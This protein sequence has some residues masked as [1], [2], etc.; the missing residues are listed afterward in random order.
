MNET[1][2]RLDGSFKQS[3]HWQVMKVAFGQIM[4]MIVKH[5][6]S[7]TN[8]KSL[9]TLEIEKRGIRKTIK[10]FLVIKEN[11]IVVH[12]WN[13]FPTEYVQSNHTYI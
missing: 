1:L 3:N 8:Y 4:I 7:K 10:K 2:Y 9:P 5:Y 6:I 12:Q 13:N 11:V